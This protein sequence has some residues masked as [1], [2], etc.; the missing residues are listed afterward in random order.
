VNK[1]IL[2]AIPAV[3]AV[4]IIGSGS[5]GFPSG[6]CCGGSSLTIPIG[7]CCSSGCCGGKASSI[8]I[9][10]TELEKKIFDT[11]V[12]DHSLDSR[13]A[14][15]F[16]NI[17]DNGKLELQDRLI[18]SSLKK[19]DLTLAK[20]ILFAKLL[21]ED[22]LLL[23]KQLIFNAVHEFDTHNFHDYDHDLHLG[24]GLQFQEALDDLN[25]ISGLDDSEDQENCFN[26]WIKHN[27]LQKVCP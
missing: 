2:L 4:I 10:D 8:V 18:L 20:R 15:I 11:V 17:I 7:D 24:S 27:M 26:V 9:R 12:H 16:N 22:E 13:R 6:G 23:K 14:A 3:V 5:I 19:H 1:K 21:N 25:D